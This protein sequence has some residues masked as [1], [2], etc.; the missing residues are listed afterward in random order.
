MVDLA[1]HRP[2]LLAT[3]SGLR[4]LP[5]FDSP[6][7]DGDLS[8]GFRPSQAVHLDI[9]SESELEA[10]RG[11]SRRRPNEDRRTVFRAQGGFD[12]GC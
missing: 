2:P 3:P 9:G 1:A 5:R 12:E 10:C 8:E 7:Q 4:A 11:R 6:K